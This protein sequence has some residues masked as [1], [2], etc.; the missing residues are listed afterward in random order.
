MGRIRD[1]LRVPMKPVRAPRPRKGVL[2]LR[3]ACVRWEPDIHF[4]WGEGCRSQD[5]HLINYAFNRVMDG[6]TKTLLE[7]L[8]ARGYDIT[9]IRF[10]I[11]KLPPPPGPTEA[12]QL[13]ALP[14]EQNMEGW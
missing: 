2:E 13:A 3:Y 14:R 4:C 10:S 5:G 11:K 6:E 12:Q 9:T 8:A 7:E 1:L